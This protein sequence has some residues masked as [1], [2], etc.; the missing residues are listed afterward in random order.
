[1][2][3]HRCMV[4]RCVNPVH[5][6]LATNKQNQENQA[7]PRRDNRSSEYRGVTRRADSGRWRAQVQHN[8]VRYSS[9]HDTEIEAADAARRFRLGL[10]T[11]ND[12]DRLG[13]GAVA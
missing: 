11:H 10:F 1:M 12:V 4:K 3:D 13:A 6:R 5:L 8:G 9:T 7:R 2:L